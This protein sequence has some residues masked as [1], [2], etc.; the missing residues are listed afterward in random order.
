MGEQTKRVC[1]SFAHIKLALVHLLN[2]LHAQGTDIEKK[3]PTT[4]SPGNILFQRNMNPKE[5]EYMQMSMLVKNKLT[6][7]QS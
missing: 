2:L 5:E 4:E 6:N 7:Q 3:K 1:K